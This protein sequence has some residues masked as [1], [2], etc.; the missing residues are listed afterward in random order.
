[1]TRNEWVGSIVIGA[2]IACVAFYVFMNAD[3]FMT[4]FGP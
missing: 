3:R 2:V 1:M 4:T